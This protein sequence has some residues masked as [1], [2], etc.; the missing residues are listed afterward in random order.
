MV[1]FL[2]GV[3]PSRVM[4]SSSSYASKPDAATGFC[5]ITSKPQLE[6]SSQG[7]LLTTILRS[8]GNFSIFSLQCDSEMEDQ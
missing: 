3:S 7:L 5:L 8:A 6:K 1:W 4:I 2:S